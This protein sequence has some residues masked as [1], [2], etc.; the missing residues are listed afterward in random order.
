MGIPQLTYVE[1]FIDRRVDAIL[2]SPKVADALTPVVNRAYAGG[3]PVIVLDR[4]RVIEECD[5]LGLF[6]TVRE[7]AI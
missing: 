6:L 2:I 4:D 3:I 5:R 7:R 1:E